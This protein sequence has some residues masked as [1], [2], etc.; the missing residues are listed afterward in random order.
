MAVRGEYIMIA[1]RIRDTGTG[2]CPDQIAHLFEHFNR[3]DK[4]CERDF[5]SF[6]TVLTIGHSLAE[7]T[8]NAI[9]VES[10]QRLLPYTSP[11]SCKTLFKRIFLINLDENAHLLL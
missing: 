9:W 4:S 10:A 8:G 5:G 6:G 3:V 1:F 2:P 11:G 7:E